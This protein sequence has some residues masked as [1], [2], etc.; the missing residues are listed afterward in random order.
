MKVQNTRQYKT[1]GKRKRKHEDCEV[2]KQTRIETILFGRI[3]YIVYALSS[4]VVYNGCRFP[5]KDKLQLYINTLKLFHLLCRAEYHNAT[6]LRLRIFTIY[7]ELYKNHRH[8]KSMA[9]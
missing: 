6:T 8:W 2:N 5:N 3:K 1:N 7:C 9:S 4:L